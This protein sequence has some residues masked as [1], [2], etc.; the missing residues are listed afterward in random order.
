MSRIRSRL[1]AAS[2]SMPRPVRY[3]IQ[4]DPPSGDGP[5]DPTD[6]ALATMKAAAVAEGFV[7]VVIA[8]HRI[9]T[10]PAYR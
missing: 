1:D 3:L 10:A 4:R 5:K 8:V 7:P 6:E 2:R 9:S